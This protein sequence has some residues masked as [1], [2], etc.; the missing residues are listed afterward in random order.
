L[1]QFLFQINTGLLQSST[2][3]M[4]QP[5]QNSAEVAPQSIDE[6]W[7]AENSAGYLM[8]KLQSMKESNPHLTI[9]DI[10]AGSG[11]IWTSF[12]KIIPNGHVTAAILK[13]SQLPRA[14]FLANSA[15]IK[16]VTFQQ[17]DA[18]KLPFPDGTFDITHSHQ[19]LCHRKEPVNVLCEMLRVTKPGGVVAVREGDQEMEC[20]W[21]EIP[22]LLQFHGFIS[23]LMQAG[24]GSSTAGRQLLDWTL[25]AGVKRE[26]ITATYGTWYHNG[27][28][29]KTVWGEL[30]ILER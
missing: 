9:L 26:N 20:I 29:E 27:P 1:V 4:S 17:A 8:P 5:D 18:Y 10:N 14:T 22:A 21:P 30:F 19:L 25:K 15:G 2:R 13:P 23:K 16:N 7:T 24:G 28:K 3:T 11:T 6:L 12:A